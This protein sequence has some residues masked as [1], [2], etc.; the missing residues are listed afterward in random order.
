MP[1]AWRVSL[2]APSVVFYAVALA[3][4]GHKAQMLGEHALLRGLGSEGI[5][6]S[7][8][9]VA[10]AC[11]ITSAIATLAIKAHWLLAR[12]QGAPLSGENELSHLM[13]S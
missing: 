10:F 12:E 9:E 5:P 8:A 3:F 6:V 7:F 1:F 4:F 2:R 13:P 11:V